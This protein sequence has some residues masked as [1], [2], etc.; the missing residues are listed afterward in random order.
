M[1]TSFN[2]GSGKSFISYNLGVSFALKRK[3]VLIV[4]CDL[5]HGSS[6][7]FVGMPKNGLT[8]YLTGNIDNW[9]DVV[10]KTS[11]SP[12]L[13]I[14]PIGKMPP[15]PAELLDNGR[16]KEL[17][18]EAKEDYDYVLLDCPPVNIVVDTQIVGQYADRT[19]FV[20]RAGLLDKNALGELDEFYEEK[21]FKNMSVI[22]NGT[23]ASHSRYY[24]YGTY[25]NHVN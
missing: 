21:R 25:Q 8:N 3:R 11:A 10:E 15:N 20:V 23:E 17:I 1:L 14:L 24:T 18:N 12:N 19:L 2:P 4:D 16:I 7:M 6:S 9:K 13:S 22:L 5:R